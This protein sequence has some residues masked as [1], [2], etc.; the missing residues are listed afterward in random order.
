M[1]IN[2]EAYY[3]GLTQQHIL[4]FVK[5]NANCWKMVFDY[6]SL[7]D[8]LA[9]SQTCQRMEQIGG[10]YFRENFH[11]A[12][13]SIP[14][15]VDPN[16][17]VSSMG[18][19]I[20]MEH[21]SF[22]RFADTTSL[23]NNFA[24]C[25][26]ENLL[27]RMT[28]LILFGIHLNG[29]D[30]DIN[31]SVPNNIETLKIAFCTIYKGSWIGKLL[32]LSKL[33]FLRFEC[34]EFETK[35]FRNSAFQR[36]YPMLTHFQYSDPKDETATSMMLTSFLNLNPSIKNLQ[37]SHANIEK[38]RFDEITG[39]RLN[40]FCID[41]Y[42]PFPSDISYIIIEI[43]EKMKELHKKDFFKTFRV[44]SF[45]ESSEWEKIAEKLTP[46][47]ALEALYL[48]EFHA[49]VYNL[50]QLKEFHIG[51]KIKDD[52]DLEAIAKNLVNLERLWL[53]CTGDQ[54]SLFLEHS[55]KLKM[56]I[57]KDSNKGG[58]ALNLLHLNDKRQMSGMTQKVIIGVCEH[59]Y[60][61]TKYMAIKMEYEL[62]EIVRMEKIREQ[63]AFMH[64][65]EV[66]THAIDNK[67]ISTTVEDVN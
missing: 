28:T 27:E 20:K 60:V 11:G 52:V 23:S 48:N 42:N 58:D 36:V 33:K 9:M 2:D 46:F 14:T 37:I 66:A 25:I 7:P 35:K 39:T 40:Y 53:E 63:F 31:M 41:M 43:I 34:V 22:L 54:F 16:T 8:I 12:M 6:L 38:I 64:F 10:D 49:S 45:I 57:W 5:V 15:N 51:L 47:S 65:Q 30:S 44:I 3:G 62:V 4:M 56:A 13:C 50:T 1:F 55:K 17:N 59:T 24:L 67:H 26:S 18:N 21:E 29:N 19:E 32:S 61:A